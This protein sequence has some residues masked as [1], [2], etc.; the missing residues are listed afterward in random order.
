M[1][2]IALFDE[3][4]LILDG[5]AR[6]LSDV[7]DFNLVLACDHR[8]VLIDKLKKVNV[9]V[10]IL[11][12]HDISVRNLNFI[13]QLNIDNPKLKILILSAIQNEEIILKTIKAG[14]KGFLGK[15]SDMNDL[16]EAVFTLRNG[17]DYYNKSISTLV[18]NQ[19]VS[20][21][22]ST[23]DSGSEPSQLST[24]QIEIL[25]LWGESYSNQEIA[26]QLFISVRTVESHKNHIM[27]KLNMKSTVDM[28]KFAIKNNIIDI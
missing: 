1:I 22:N 7:P 15:D 2:N 20:N 23:S 8:A 9:H 17:Y 21:I 14:A 18:V 4:K 25:R 28:V 27:Q 16:K 24:R 13:V 12:M 19:Y 5:F 3:H 6:L 10:L 11:N 26:D